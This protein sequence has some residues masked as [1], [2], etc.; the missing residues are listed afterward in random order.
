LATQ[1]NDRQSMASALRAPGERVLTI[2]PPD[3]EWAQ[4]LEAIA[5]PM[6]ELSRAVDRGESADYDALDEASKDASAQFDRLMRR[7]SLPYRVLTWV[8][9]G[10]GG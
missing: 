8:P 10:E 1:W 3:E 9:R 7:R 5:A 6:I 2:K 4:V